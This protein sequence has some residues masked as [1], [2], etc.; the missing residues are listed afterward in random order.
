MGEPAPE[1][2]V[3]FEEVDESIVRPTRPRWNQKQCCYTLLGIIAC[4][5]LLRVVLSDA[6]G[7]AS[8]VSKLKTSKKLLPYYDEEFRLQLGLVTAEEIHRE[9][10][11]HYATVVLIYRKSKGPNANVEFLLTRRSSKVLVCP[12]EWLMVGEHAQSEEGPI[13]MTLRGLREELGLFL[14]DEDVDHLR[15]VTVQHKLESGHVEHQRTH[16]T[17]IQFPN[18]QHIDI[19]HETVSN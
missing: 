5:T 9:G 12:D 15:D 11:P 16:L 13:P 17:M 6:F 19:D 1:C 10:L 4:I 2:P 8:G 3:K 18:F 7:V 14:S